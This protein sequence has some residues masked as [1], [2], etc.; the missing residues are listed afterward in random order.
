MQ[1]HRF[2]TGGL[3]S[4]IKVAKSWEK[5]YDKRKYPREGIK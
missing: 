3:V 2:I 5:G 4:V 1:G